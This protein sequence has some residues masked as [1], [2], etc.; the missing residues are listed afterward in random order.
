MIVAGVVTIPATLSL[1]FLL[2]V[3][4]DPDPFDSAWAFLWGAVAVG[5]GLITAGI[6]HIVS[7]AWTGRRIA[8]V[9]LLRL[10]SI[11]HALVVVGVCSACFAMKAP[12]HAALSLPS[13]SG[14][15]AIGSVSL[16]LV[17]R[18]RWDPLAPTRTRRSLM[19]TLW[20]PALQTAAGTAAYLD[21]GVARVVDRELNVAAGTFETATSHARTEAAAVVRKGRAYPVVIYSP[22]FGS[23]R[24][25]STALTEE[26]VSR[27]FVVV[28]IDHPFDAAAVEFPNGTI[29][30]ARPL[31][32]PANT[33]LLTFDAWDAMVKPFLSVRVDDV[34]F[35]LD[36][37]ETLN[38][39][40]NPDADRC[41]LPSHLAGALDLHRIGMFGHSLGGATTAQAM[42]IETRIRAGLS[43]DGPIPKVSKAPCIEQ[44]IMLIRSVDPA[45]ERLTVPSW[46]PSAAAVCAWC[47]AVALTGSGHNDFTDLT[48]FAHQLALGRRQRATWSL[49]SIDARKAVDA[50]R[51]YVVTFFTRWLSGRN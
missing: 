8:K 31:A 51:R 16:H 50:E 32:V 25:A 26:L 3:G 44:P 33:K 37:L 38:A 39:G 48:V 20:Y 10:S 14:A 43:L 12:P 23:W 2:H 49:G 5:L 15:L 1:I 11:A 42:R 35:V 22:G 41:S 45:I 30:K 6:L 13:P 46:K 18:S 7:L 40:R 24:N 29:V 19:V 27:G 21:R 34:R 9:R 4:A 17:D 36:V 47:R 28:T